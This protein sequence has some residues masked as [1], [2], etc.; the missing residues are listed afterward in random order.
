MTFC[1]WCISIPLGIISIVLGIVQL[2][3]KAAKGMAIAGIVCSAVGVILAIALVVYA[4][5]IRSNY[6][7]NSL[8]NEIYQEILDEM[9][10]Y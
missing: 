8:Y 7:G 4:N 9:Y 5:F 1:I 3:K 10:D 2:Q 6:M